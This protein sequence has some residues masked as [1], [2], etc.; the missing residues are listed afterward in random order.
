MIAFHCGGK[1]T[2]RAEGQ[3]LQG[4]VTRCL[5]DALS[6]LVGRFQFRFLGCDQAK[7]DNAVIG[8]MSQYFK[9]ARTLI[10]VFEQE[11]LD[12]AAAEELRDRFII[13][14]SEEHTLVVPTAEMDGEGH[15]GMTINDG[16]VQL[17]IAGKQFV[18]ILTASPKDLA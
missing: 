2:L 11:V 16:V 4:H 9:S 15:A 5:L 17:K 13:T 14:W 1:T 7:H 18:W 6:Q 12:V 8:H 3:T 10:V